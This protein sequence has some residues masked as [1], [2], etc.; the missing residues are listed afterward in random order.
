MK[1]GDLIKGYTPN[2]YQPQVGLI[3]KTD[4]IWNGNEIMPS[5][6]EVLWNTG[7]IEKVSTDDLMVISE[8]R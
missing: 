6:I 5:M 1:V 2:P 4:P 8:S 7:E 3:I